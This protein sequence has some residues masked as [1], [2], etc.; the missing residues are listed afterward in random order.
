MNYLKEENENGNQIFYFYGE[1]DSSNC[2]IYKEKI[3]SCI[4][5]KKSN[6]IIFDFTYTTFVDS[7]GIGL[8]LGRFNE[9]KTM[10]R[11]LRLRG[12]NIYVNKIFKIAGLYQILNIE[13]IESKVKNR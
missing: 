11:N 3:S 1:L 4:E 8:I 13:C 7:A 9:I 2:F 10:N 5:R 12:V 6:L